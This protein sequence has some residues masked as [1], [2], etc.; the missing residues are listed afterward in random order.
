MFRATFFFEFVKSEIGTPVRLCSNKC[1]R[2]RHSRHTALE[3]TNREHIFKTLKGTAREPN[4]DR[5]SQTVRSVCETETILMKDPYHIG[6]M[7]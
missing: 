7:T 6:Q 2:C 3:R 4:H 5:Q 1:P